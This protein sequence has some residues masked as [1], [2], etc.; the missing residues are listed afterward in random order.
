M[1]IQDD[2]TIDYVELKI[3]YTPTFAH[4]RPAT[5]YTVNQLYS[6]LQDT[7]DEPAQMDD[8]VPMSAQTPTQ[9]TLINK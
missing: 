3:T 9:Y 1:A 5:I 8:P 7:F 4:D 2:F 6:F